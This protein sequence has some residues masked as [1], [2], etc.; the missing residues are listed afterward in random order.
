MIEFEGLDIV[1]E[2]RKRRS[3]TKLIKTPRKKQQWKKLTKEGS[4]RAVLKR[5]NITEADY[6]KMLQEQEEKCSICTVHFSET[7]RQV[8]V[9]DHC[10]TTGKVRGLLCDNCNMA[11]GLFK[12]NKDTLLKAAEYLR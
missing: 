2:E 10:H 9:V 5:Y 12:D 11:L 7:R 6:S 1:V 4:R 3:D 8:L